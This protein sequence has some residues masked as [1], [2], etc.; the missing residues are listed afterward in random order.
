MG[1][2]VFQIVRMVCVKVL[3]WICVDQIK[4]SGDEVR[5]VGVRGKRRIGVGGVGF[6]FYRFFKSLVFRWVRSFLY[7][8]QGYQ[9]VVFSYFFVKEGREELEGIQLVGTVLGSSKVFVR[10][11]SV[12]FYFIIFRL[13]SKLGVVV[14]VFFRVIFFF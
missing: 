10:F 7:F 13:K 1:E 8:S 4:C 11:G 6:F 3:R 14:F 2:M 9:F 12:L 5:V